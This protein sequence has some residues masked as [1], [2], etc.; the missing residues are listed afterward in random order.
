MR[1]AFSPTNRKCNNIANLA[2]QMAINACL[3]ELTQEIAASK[4]DVVPVIDGNSN[5]K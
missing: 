3:D 4:L 2:Q 5:A 1:N